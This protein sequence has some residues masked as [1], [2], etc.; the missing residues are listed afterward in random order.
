MGPLF[1]TLLSVT[2]ADEWD[3]RLSHAGP[4]QIRYQTLQ[5]VQDL[6]IA[7]ARRRPLVLVLEDL[8]WADDLS[9]DL[10]SLLMDRLAEAPM[11]LI[12]VYRPERDH[13]CWQIASIASRK[14]SDRFAEIRLRELTTL[15]SSA[16]V[17]S[18]LRQ[19]ALP[20]GV[21]EDILARAQGNPFFIEEIVHSLIGQGRITRDGTTW[22]GTPAEEGQTR[23]AGHPRERT[24][25]HSEPRRPPAA[26]DPTGLADG[27]GAG[28]AF[29]TARSWRR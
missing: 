14:C 12:C 25:R 21:K 18:L 28:P 5:A 13:R 23:R 1:G 27:G 29:P 17:S 6:L 24:R 9:I 2:F 22:H 11:L 3:S 8:H 15:Q 26:V 16:L 4:E 7:V 20:V 19:E 10:I